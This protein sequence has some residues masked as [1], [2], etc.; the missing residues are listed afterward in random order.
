MSKY[1]T[2]VSP[3]NPNASQSVLLELAGSDRRVLDVGCGGGGL[4]RAL[5]R[6]G[7]TVSGVDMDLEAVEEARGSLEEVLIGN[8]EDLDLVGHFGEQSFDVVVFGDVLEHLRRPDAVLREAA[9]LLRPG[10]SVVLSVPNVAHGD[11]RLLLLAGF[12]DY[13]DLGLLDETHIR[14]FTHSGV[15]RLLALAGFTATEFRRVRVPL[16]GTELGVHR[17]H[18]PPEVV[19][20]VEGSPESETYQFVVRAYPANLDGDL[21]QLRRTVDD[22][23]DKVVE[24]ETTLRDLQ[25]HAVTLTEERD[26]ERGRA[27]VLAQEIGS[28]RGLW[29]FRLSRAPRR[30][31]AALRAPRG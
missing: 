11:L 4:A 23:E 24:L 13:R 28:L 17:E 30:V 7:C 25:K 9:R 20:F 29:L 12:W 2:E 31:Y 27:D 26:V 5:A 18:F 1:E 3:G 10:G 16:F 6:Q 22:L 19:A 14:F 8:L 21:V 15:R